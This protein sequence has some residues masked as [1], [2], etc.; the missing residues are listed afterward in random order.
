TRVA[1][2]LD[3][4][5]S[6][7]VVFRRPAARG[8]AWVARDGVRFA[9]VGAPPAPVVD[10]AKVA[11]TFTVSVWAKPDVDLRVM[12]KEATSG[13]LNETGKNYVVPSREGDLLYGAGHASMGLAVGRHG[14]YVVEGSSKSSPA[15]LVVN[16]PIA[17]WTHFAVVYRDGV[18][19]LYIGGKLA[20]TRLEN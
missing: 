1:L 20:R 12:P 9:G 8:A 11:G 13:R 16:T 7:F 14:A 2:H 18:P 5:Q 6:L 15:V 3:P 4:A 17:G 19:S 10:P